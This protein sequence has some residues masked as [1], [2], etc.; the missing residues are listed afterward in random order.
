VW[1][2]AKFRALSAAKPNAQTL[3]FRLLFG[4]ELGVVPGLFGARE[5]GLADALRWKLT[6][7]RRCWAE[8]AKAKLAMADWEAGL[9]WV[10]NAIFH[11]PPA[12]PNVVKGWRTAILEL[13]EC[14]LK[15]EGLEKLEAHLEAQGKAWGDACR[16]AL[17]KPSRKAFATPSPNQ[18]QDQDSGSGSMQSS[19]S[20]LDP[21]LRGR[22]RTKQAPPLPPNGI[23]AE[24]ATESEARGVSHTWHLAMHQV[25]PGFVHGFEQWRADFELVAIALNHSAGGEA[26]RLSIARAALCAWFW[27]APEGPVQSGRVPARRASPKLLAKHV[28]TDLEA[29]KDWWLMLSDAEQDALLEATTPPAIARVGS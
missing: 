24:A 4:P 8:V 17:D 28:S 6:D 26:E 10:P 25:A 14:R 29:A 5:G 27:R 11:N 18:D 22:A 12:S 15:R 13:P 16:Q 1:A 7:F 19:N 2:D 23:G 20:D 21:D 3:W 9:V